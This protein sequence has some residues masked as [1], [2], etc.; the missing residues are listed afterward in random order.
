MCESSESSQFSLL[1]TLSSIV[2]LRTVLFILFSANFANVLKICR[3]AVILLKIICNFHGPN[4]IPLH[5]L[6]ESRDCCVNLLN[7]P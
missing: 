4:Y 3:F 2:D 6:S 7:V 1:C 5:S